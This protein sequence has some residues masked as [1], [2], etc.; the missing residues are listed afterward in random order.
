VRPIDLLAPPG[1]GICLAGP[2]PVCARCLAAL[3]LLDGPRCGRC[4][5]PTLRDVRECRACRGRRLGFG[6]ARAAILY[7]GR[8]RDLVHAFK[9]GGQRAL[10]SPAAGLVA[11]V[12]EPPPADVVTWVAADRWRLIH[13]GYHPPE[14]LAREL[15][16]RWGLE[17]EPLL[18]AAAWRRPQ[19]G[20]DVAA[21]RAN[22]RDVF[23]ARPAGG[24]RIAL[25]DDVHT[26][27]ATLSAAAAALRRAGAQEVHAVA[28][29]RAA[30]G[31]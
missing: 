20:L 11:V 29:A 16:R 21:R 7:A 5:T 19:R 30:D 1:C 25:V 14:L 8:A 15:A 22:V 12:V 24:R 13:R 3:P 23:R 26:T 2:G 17:A 18:E 4:G 27:G 9:D 28:L 6:S 31:R 10:A